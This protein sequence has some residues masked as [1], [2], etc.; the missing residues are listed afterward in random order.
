[1][2]V[3]KVSLEVKE[4]R[5][6]LADISINKNAVYGDTSAMNPEVFVLVVQQ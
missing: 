5:C 4:K 1:M 6:E 3:I 2:F